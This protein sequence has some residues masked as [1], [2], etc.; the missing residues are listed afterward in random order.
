MADSSNTEKTY[1]LDSESAA[2]MARLLSQDLIITKAMED[3]FPEHI[4]MSSLHDVLDVACGPGGWALEV[5]YEYPDINVV[6]I[7]ASRPMI[8][9]ATMRAETQR[10][11][12][13][14]FR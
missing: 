10:L 9:Y 2:E 7:D 14:S 11:S 4:D 1:L 13:A 12:N 3:L 8:Q 6:G 5:A